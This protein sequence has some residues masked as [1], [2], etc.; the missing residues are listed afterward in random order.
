MSN[1]LK[2]AQEF[3]SLWRLCE[4][5]LFWRWRLVFIDPQSKLAITP[6]LASLTVW[7]LLKMSHWIRP[8]HIWVDSKYPRIDS[9]FCS[10]SSGRLVH[11]DLEI[12]LIDFFCMGRSDPRRVDSS[13]LC[14]KSAHWIFLYGSTHSMSEST[15]ASQHQNL[16]SVFLCTL[17]AGQPK[18]CMGRLDP[19]A[20]T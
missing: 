6:L 9:S 18:Q 5:L 13:S 12:R 19:C 4:K 14:Q 10:N 3:F 20:K 16:V 11:V 2:L 8:F 7:K 15:R 17:Y 1:S